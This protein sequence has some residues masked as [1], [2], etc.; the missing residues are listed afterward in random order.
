MT[1]RK[2][3]ALDTS[4]SDLIEQVGKKRS[5]CHERQ[6]LGPIGHDSSQ[7]RSHPPG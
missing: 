6:H 2:H 1:R 3:N 4:A 5:A 7:P